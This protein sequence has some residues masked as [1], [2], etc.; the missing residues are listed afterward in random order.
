MS[1]FSGVPA[2]VS[3]LAAR[4]EAGTPMSRLADAV[5]ASTGLSRAEAER[6]AQ[7]VEDLAPMGA[8]LP[9]CRCA[10]CAAATALWMGG[11]AGERVARRATRAQE[12]MAASSPAPTRAV[13]LQLDILGGR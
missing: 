8:E 6:I 13:G 2:D 12:A 4:Y 10:F 7:A 11:A 1:D 9:G 5:E 3:D